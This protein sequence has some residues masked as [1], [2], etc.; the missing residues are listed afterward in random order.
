[1]TG[2]LN[3]MTR[4]ATIAAAAL[5]LLALTGCAGSADEAPSAPRGFAQSIPSETPESAAESTPSDIT[6]PG[7]VCDPS[8]A[9]DA[10]CAAFFPAQAVINMTNRTPALAV[11]PE[12]ER[13]ELAHQACDD[14]TTVLVEDA[15]GDINLHKAA[16]FSYCNEN[17]EPGSFPGQPDRNQRIIAFYQSIG[18]AAAV[19]HFADKV[20][21]TAEELGY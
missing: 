20:M 6:A 8:N 16:A 12:P 10:I 18:K 3:G 9:N 19:E 13:I 14:F 4:T 11:I 5:L 2:T 17:M 21:P 1:M 7:E 15:Q